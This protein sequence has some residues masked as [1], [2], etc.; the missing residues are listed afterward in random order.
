LNNNFTASVIYD[1]PFGNGKKFGNDWG[2]PLNTLLGNWQVTTIE[3]ITS[4][5]PIFI[6][7]SNNQSGVNFQNNGNSLNRPDE[8]SNPNTGGAVT[9]NPGCNAPANVHTVGNWFNPCAF[10]AAPVGEL[11]DASRTPLSGPGF[12][13]TDFSLIKQFRLPWENL[14]LNFRAEIF[15]LFNHPQFA[16]PN[17]D[18]NVPI[19]GGVPQGFGS[20]NSTVNNP[21]LFQFALKLTF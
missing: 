3:K 20:I 21:R 4:G 18:L 14:G 17:S 9:A 15:N 12:V 11:G 10:V 6:I 8:V 19:V 2:T 5:F 16:T 13:N 7:N 1:L